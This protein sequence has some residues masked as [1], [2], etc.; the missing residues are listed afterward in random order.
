MSHLL[1]AKS[2]VAPIITITLPRLE[3]CSAVTLAHLARKIQESL[4]ISFNNKYF[5]TDSMV[6]LNWIQ[7]EPGKWKTFVANRVSEIQALTEINEWHH[8]R[9]HD[10]IP[11]H[12]NSDLW[13]HGPDWLKRHNSKWDVKEVSINSEI[14]E[15]KVILSHV[16]IENES[17][18]FIQNLLN[19]F[20]SLTKI[21]RVLSY[22][23]RFYNCR[24][25][26]KHNGF[27]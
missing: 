12:E 20:S 23:F 1:C 2:C 25:K 19:R 15:Q 11:T 16:L 4:K 9:T 8:V 14:P 5:W 3:L 13:W 6:T 10:S 17:L 21:I 24:S 18:I 22:I 26:T 27:A 7:G